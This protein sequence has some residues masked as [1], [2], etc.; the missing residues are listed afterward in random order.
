MEHGNGR[1]RVLPEK[2]AI[3]F[4]IW[5]LWDTD[6]TGCFHDLDRLMEEHAA[7]GYNC[8]RLEDGAALIHD[9]KGNPLGAVE[10]RHPFDGYTGNLRQNGCMGG[11]GKVD[12]LAR[13]IAWCEAAKRHNMYLILSSWYY[14]HT[15]WICGNESINDMMFALP[16]HE[17][18]GV[19]GKF[20]DYILC[21]LEKR[22]LDDC[23]AYAEVYNEADALRTLSFCDPPETFDAKE[24]AMFTAEHEAAIASLREHHP[25]ILFAYDTCGAATPLEKIPKNAQV[26]NFHNYFAWQLYM[27]TLEQVPEGKELFV[28]DPVPIETIRGIRKGRRPLYD[29]GWYD[30][31]FYYTNLDK[32]KLYKAELAL[33]REMERTAPLLRGKVDDTVAALKRT[34]SGLPEGVRAACGEGVTYCGSYALL[35]EEHCPAFWDLVEYALRRYRDAGVWGSVIKTNCSPEDPG[36]NLCEERIRRCNGI[37][38]GT[39][40]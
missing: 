5:G 11:E 29:G 8:I 4:T 34:L 21:E 24:I 17:R 31:L 20:L 30:R 13:L 18:F 19:L 1:Q 37:T 7:R 14:L 12:L 33:N 10:Y 25:Q 27:N 15:Y 3:S 23:I 36:W 35:W 22:G 2:L 32:N 38:M 28:A 39:I 26:F 9:I 16:R 6:G 40:D